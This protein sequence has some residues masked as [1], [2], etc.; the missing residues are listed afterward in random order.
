MPA[1]VRKPAVATPPITTR[2]TYG[3]RGLADVEGD[4]IV[5]DVMRGWEVYDDPKLVEARQVAH[6]RRKAEAVAYF[7]AALAK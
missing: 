2:L 7:T 5:G 4:G 1:A 3:A 6:E